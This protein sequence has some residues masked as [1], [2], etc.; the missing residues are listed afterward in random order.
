MHHI[1]PSFGLYWLLKGTKTIHMRKVG[2]LTLAWVLIGFTLKAQTGRIRLKV[3]DS[4]NRKLAAVTATLLRT[5][6]TGIVKVELSDGEGQVDFQKL[7]PGAYTVALTSTGF[8]PLQ[9]PIVTISADQPVKDLGALQMQ[10]ASKNLEAV[11]I[12]SR[13]PFIEQKIDKMVVNVD[14]AV[15]NAGS[16]VLEVLEKSPGITVDNDGNISLKGKQQVL[17]M[18]DGKPT[19]LGPTELANLLKSMPSSLV[20]QIEIMTNP[21]SKY[22]AAGN[23]GIINI[24]T[25]KNK[26]YGFNGSI[27]LAYTQGRYWRSN[28]NF[29]LNY[30]NGKFNFFANGSY[31]KWNSFQ[32]LEI[33]RTFV[34]PQTG[35]KDAVFEQVTHMRN[36][37]DN[38][39]LKLGAD[40]FLS[41]KTT[42]GVVATGLR[43][44]ERFSSNGLSFLMNGGG[45]TDSVVQANSHNDNIWKNGTVNLNLRHRFDST[46]K[47]LTAD[48]DYAAYNSRTAQTFTNTTFD[49]K[50]N[51][52]HEENLRGDLPVTIRIYTAK[53]DYTQTLGKAKIET[54]VKS[55]YVNTTNAANYFIVSNGG[56]T[57]DYG[58]TNMFDY[59]ENINAA[60]LNYSRQFGK[61]GVQAGLRYEYT[62]LEGYQHGNPQRSDSLFQRNYGNLFPTLFLSYEAGKNHQWG[63][64]IGR[65]IDRPAYQDLNPFLFFLDNYTYQA[66]NP[67]LRP[68]YTNNVELSHTFKGFLTT[69]LNYSHTKDFHTETFEQV[70][71]PNGEMGYATI[72]RQGNIGRRDNA[73][74]SVSAQIPVQK[75]WTAIVYTNFNYSKFRGDLNNETVDVEASTLLLNI[76]NQ[77]KFKK[78]W[79]AE[80]SGFYR[81]KG[82]EGQILINPLGQASAGAAKQVLKGKGTMKLSLRDMFYTNKVSGNI[83]FQNTQAYFRNVRDT[84]QITV[85]FLYRFGKPIKGAPQRRNGGSGDEQNRVK[86]GN[87]G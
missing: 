6:D 66:G 31:S 55:S 4:E 84:R 38:Y 70:E 15:T 14:A 5:K 39:S 45:N 49:P 77:F 87:N 53:M 86:M 16:T 75:W 35:V 7:T 8:Q 72:V 52:L 10:P 62:W 26:Q 25:K 80:L 46:G 50:M 54:G 13:K 1:V 11:T 68:Q 74:I 79:S 85:S 73:G 9:S 76:N 32:D 56:E 21:S 33:K 43:N 69:T 27:N 3:E 59:K 40:Y 18:M 71:L 19:Y 78:G 36:I 28:D 2:M 81:T 12:T 58:K 37:S 48:L 22:D 44:P 41:K 51:M 64:N 23:S 47:E 65:R 63:F 17:V 67:Y 57:V 20:E 82:A 30:R 24:R 83:N 42:L 34:D 29:N 61:L 60:Y